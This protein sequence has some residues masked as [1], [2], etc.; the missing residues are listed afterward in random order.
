MEMSEL[1]ELLDYAEKMANGIDPTT[2]IAFCEDTVL[3]NFM[4]K[5]YNLKVAR[6]LLD[7]IRSDRKTQAPGGKIV[8]N[9]SQNEKESFVY[10]DYSISISALVYQM[11]GYC[12]PYM[13]KLH[14]TDITKWM[15][16]NG[17]LE[18]KETE[19]GM[20]YKVAT[21]KGNEL[22]IFNYKKRNKYGNEYSVNLYDVFAQKFI[23]NNIERMVQNAIYS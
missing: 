15:Q 17:Y 13:K 23:V 8:F 12:K 3:N 9:M 14:A 6:I 19:S 16:E 18:T 22:G 1:I 21:Q 5:Q 20:L 11:N 10:S 4:I 7:L 2:N